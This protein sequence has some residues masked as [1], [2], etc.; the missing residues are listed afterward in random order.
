M[1]CRRRRRRRLLPP[2]CCRFCSLLLLDLRCLTA[3]ARSRQRRL[4]WDRRRGFF[5][6]NLHTLEINTPEEALVA[7]Q[8]GVKNKIMAK[9]NQN[10][11]SSRSHCIFQ[12]S[13]RDG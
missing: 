13:H 10:L 5:A 11:A 2:C 7:L 1:N 9:H 6:E 4:R 3:T 8:G 12:V